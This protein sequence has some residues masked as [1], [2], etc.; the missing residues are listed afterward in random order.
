M[1]PDEVVLENL[2]EPPHSAEAEQS[3]L[4]ALLLDNQAFDKVAWLEAGAFY[5]DRHRRLWSAIVRLLEAGK[6]ADLTTVSDALGEDLEKVGGL[7]YIGALEQ[8]TPSAVNIVRYAELVQKNALLRSIAQRSMETA[9]RAMA[10]TE[11]PLV[12]ADDGAA[13]LLALQ[14]QADSG[15]A[16][17]FGA[18]LV[19]AVEWADNPGRGLTTGYSAVDNILR[20]LM[21][22]DFIVIAG[23]PSMGKTAL[24]MN[25][26]EHVAAREHV[27]ILS[28]EM[29]KRKIAGRALRY[30]DSILGRDGALDHLYGLKLHIDDSSAMTLGQVRARLRRVKHKHGLALAV[31]D[32]LQLL[33][34]KAEKRHEEVATI[35]RGL[36]A[37]AKD[38]NIPIIA[39]A[40][41]NRAAEGR[42]DN[43][44]QLADLR[45]SGQIEQ[46][47]D[48]VAFVYREDYYRADTPW[49]GIAELIVRKHRDGP[50]GTAYLKFI[51][52]F[53]RF[54]T[55]DGPLPQR[56]EPEPEK[57]RRT[58]VRADFKRDAAADR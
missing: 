34:A 16:T 28:L 56:E 18:A 42:P 27:A 25:I 8:N 45:E 48:I 35:S 11:E 52:E 9:E 53:T 22:G 6:A 50:V 24:A 58:V 21:P 14:A 33:T 12:I 41:L 38:L 26:A 54:L 2:R 37:I 47:A 32:Y 23:R 39:V 40:Q 51:P 43:R 5:Q 55:M 17:E 30:H 49:R 31:I 36:K 10:G 13:A 57:P 7:A 15:D 20:G 1:H 4:G 19:E 3:T 29:T 46:D 44:P